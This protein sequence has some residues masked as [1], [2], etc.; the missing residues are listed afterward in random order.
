MAKKKDHGQLDT[1]ILDAVSH[2]PQRPESLL[3]NSVVRSA[4]MRVTRRRAGASPAQ[5][6]DTT[7]MERL[8][9][10]RLTGQISFDHSTGRWN[11][12]VVAAS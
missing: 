4:A 7:I 3:A 1:S 8:N 11:R 12:V 10:L 2:L 5:S 9:V 6:T